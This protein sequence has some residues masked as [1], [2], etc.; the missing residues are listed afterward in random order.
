M[1]K[2]QRISKDGLNPIGPWHWLKAE[3]TAN[4]LLECLEN[5]LQFDRVELLI[6]LSKEKLIEKLDELE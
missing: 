2:I 1:T 6:D 3:K 4:E 5:D